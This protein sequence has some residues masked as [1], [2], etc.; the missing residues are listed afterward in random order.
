MAQWVGDPK[1]E[2]YEVECK[3]ELYIVN[4]GA[5][6]C[7]YRSWGLCRI[8]CPH[9]VATIGWRHLK[10]K[11]FMHPNLI[12]DTFAKVYKPYIQLING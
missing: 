8:P 12:K 3:L 6:I 4:L 9:V 7:S 10:L 5:H 1:R 11:D 2:K